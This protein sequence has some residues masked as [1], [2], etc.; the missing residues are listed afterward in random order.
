MIQLTEIQN[1]AMATK[2]RLCMEL[3]SLRI[4]NINTQVIHGIS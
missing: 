2:N 1:K 3:G 4:L